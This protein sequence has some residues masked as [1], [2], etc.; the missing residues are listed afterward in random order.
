V[1][2]G[3]G[4]HGTTLPGILFGDVWVCGGQSNMEQ[5]MRDIERPEGEMAESA[6]DSGI[7]FMD[8]A[9]RESEQELEELEDVPLALPWSGP[10]DRARLAEMSAVCF[11]TGRRWHRTLGVPIGLIATTWGGTEIEAWMN[12]W[13]EYIR[14]CSRMRPTCRPALAR[15]SSPPPHPRH[16]NRTAAD[17]T[18]KKNCDSALWNAMVA[19]LRYLHIA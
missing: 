6:G 2:V 15:C 4:R 19:P 13:A 3:E 5:K 9:R 12:R 1:Q 11:L 14:V 18:R 16:C 7:R 17:P 8:L 10:A